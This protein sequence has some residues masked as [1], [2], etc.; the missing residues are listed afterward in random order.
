[1]NLL[2]KLKSLFKR[3]E[4]D[5]ICHCGGDP[6]AHVTGTQGCLRLMTIPPTD[7]GNGFWEIDGNMITGYMLRAQRGYHQHPCGCWS[8][9]VEGSDNS[10]SA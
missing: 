6:D 8:R 3:V 4:H 9:R 7:L 2:K 10:I 1:M 5:H